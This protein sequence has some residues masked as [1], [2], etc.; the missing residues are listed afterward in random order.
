MDKYQKY[1]AESGKPG[2][3]KTDIYT[4]GF[5]YEVLLGR[6][7]NKLP[8]VMEMFCFPKSICQN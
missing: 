1:Y 7:I 5:L 8:G 3:E 6:G 4:L 2:G